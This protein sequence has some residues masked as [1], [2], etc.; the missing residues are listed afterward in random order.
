MSIEDT[1]TCTGIDAATQALRIIRF[2]G[3]N[4]HPTAVWMQKWAAWGMEPTK[5]PKPEPEPPKETV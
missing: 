5:W 4:G 2:S 3:N 1:T